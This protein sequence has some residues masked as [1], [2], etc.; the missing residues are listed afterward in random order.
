MQ[1]IKKR[2]LDPTR[3]VLR[4]PLW[5]LERSDQLHTHL[6]WNSR[7]RPPHS[8]R[9]SRTP[10]SHN[11]RLTAP[12][13]ITNTYR[14]HV[15]DH[16]TTKLAE[17]HTSLTASLDTFIGQSSSPSES[18]GN[19]TQP[20]FAI[21]CQVDAITENLRT[22]FGA[23]RICTKS[24]NEAGEEVEHEELLSDKMV[25]YVE[26]LEKEKEEVKKLQS[27][28]ELVVGEIWKLGVQALGKS[29][30]SELFVT[31]SPPTSP[32]LKSPAKVDILGFEPDCDDPASV[33]VRPKKS[34]K[35]VSFVDQAQRP[36][37]LNGPSV[38]SKRIPPIPNFPTNEIG[39]LEKAIDELGAK[40][41]AKL[42]KAEKD[43]QAHWAKKNAAIAMIFQE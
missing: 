40:E 19:P 27:E 42:Q 10:S 4:S 3:A 7:V 2:S 5:H 39:T 13:E 33:A 9:Q 28:W 11:S 8:S 37:F 23:H 25:N 24:T 36:H 1:E 38:L 29:R 30:M 35:S 12:L 31:S 21:T 22:E 15:Y 32:T 34:K 20:K 26:H 17:I 14:V 16:A 43:Y 6:S 41:V 18:Q